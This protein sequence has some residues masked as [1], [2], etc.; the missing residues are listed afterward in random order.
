MGQLDDK[1]FAHTDKFLGGRKGSGGSYTL[2]I[3]RAGE[4]KIPLHGV[5]Y[6][7]ILHNY[8]N[9]E[10]DGQI[11]IAG[12]QLWGIMDTGSF[13]LLAFDKDRGQMPWLWTGFYFGLR[14][15]CMPH[16]G[17]LSGSCI[18]YGSGKTC[19]NQAASEV[20]VGPLTSEGQDFLL[21]YS[22][23]MPLLAEADF[24]AIVGLGVPKGDELLV[25]LGVQYLS[26][27][28][29]ANADGKMVW[30]DNAPGSA[31]TSMSV[32]GQ[33]F[34]GLVM[35]DAETLSN[36]EKT[37][38]VGCNPSCGAVLD[39]GTSLIGAPQSFIREVVKAF[40]DMGGSCSDI[41]SLP[42]LKFKLNGNDFSL[43]PEAYVGRYVTKSIKWLPDWV[44]QPVMIGCELLLID[45]G[46]VNTEKGKML[47]L[48]MPFF[49][50]YYTTFDLGSPGGS[51]VGSMKVHTAPTGASC[52]PGTRLAD[53]AMGGTRRLMDV[54]PARVILPKWLNRAMAAGDT[55]KG[56]TNITIPF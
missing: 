8:G 41:S 54:D 20:S 45:V 49:R 50:F 11:T 16:Q 22:A 12:Q 33:V 55:R 7:Q 21:A 14:G 37:H 6:E 30:N 31:F 34:W 29:P 2:G 32:A 1:P 4:G 56:P 38:S 28:M 36:G 15:A 24:Q 42:S 26:V 5:K 39:T 53:G 19:A 23:E 3:P 52:M 40:A 13:D 35:T 46:D 43:P 44:P 51:N 17:E 9:V 48:G 47:I 10:Y 27:C 18:E 25:K